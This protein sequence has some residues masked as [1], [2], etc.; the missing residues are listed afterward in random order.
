MISR[1]SIFAIIACGDYN[2]VLRLQEAGASRRLT[3]TA[4]TASGSFSV[5]NGQ[6]IDPHGSR[7]VAR[8]INIHN[9]T[10]NTAVSDASCKPLLTRF[11]GINMVRI[12][13]EDNYNADSDPRLQNA[14]TW[15]TA[16]GIVV[17]FGN[18]TITT[19]VATGQNL[20]DFRSML[21]RMNKK[22][23]DNPYVWYSTCNEPSD[24][25]TYAGA[26]M[27]E[28]KAVYNAI[29]AI[30]ST[31]MLGLLDPWTNATTPSIYTTMTNVYW[32][33]HCYPWTTR[34]STN[35][36]DYENWIR[37]RVDYLQTFKTADGVPPALNGE[38]GN[39]TTGYSHD[40]NYP[41]SGEANVT[42]CITEGNKYSGWVA[43]LWFWPG[44]AYISDQVHD[45]ALVDERS[46]NGV[47]T[48]YPLVHPY[49][50]MIAGFIGSTPPPL[51]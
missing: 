6:I 8:G 30:S 39:S 20:T 46:V 19:S 2:R 11:P 22:Y 9:G 32:D 51:P 31:A 35:P 16:N 23:K 12:A 44:N 41:K 42:G 37:N 47:P 25:H 10:I 27:D 49:G 4:G 5:S 50:T 13:I 15:L 14:V 45:D 1:R 48:V 26:T 36:V 29:R 17:Q 7:F 43:W 21:T 24:Q 28:Q 33:Y 38:F 34:Q 18:Y 3:T 40:A